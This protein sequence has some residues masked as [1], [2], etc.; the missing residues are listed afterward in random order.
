MA[1]LRTPIDGE[2]R[3]QFAADGLILRMPQMSDYPAW[4]E[5]RAKSRLHLVPW[6][7]TWA[8]DELSRSSYKLRLRHYDKELREQTG[9]AFFLIRQ[10]DRALVGGITLSNLRRG[11]TQSATLGYWVGASF[12]GRGYMTAGVKA[13]CGF[14]FDALRLHRV[15]AACLVGNA[16]SVRVLE[17]CGFSREGLARRYLKINGAWQDHILFARLSDDAA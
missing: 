11:V 13:V 9:F 7:P 2:A 8:P 4:A 16:A 3:P 12:A 15:E 14:A 17:K 5:L 10:H 6:E 1:F